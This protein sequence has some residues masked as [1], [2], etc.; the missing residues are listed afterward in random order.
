M[1]IIDSIKNREQFSIKN[2]HVL[3]QSNVGDKLRFSVCKHVGSGNYGNPTYLYYDT[4]K[5][6][7]TL[8]SMILNDINS[9]YCDN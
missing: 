6:P 3:Q 8:L 1:K 9:G 7:E 5:T 4:D 2:Y